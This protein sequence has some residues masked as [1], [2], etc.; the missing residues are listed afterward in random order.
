[1]TSGYRGHDLTRW[2]TAG[3]SFVECMDGCGRLGGHR[4]LPGSL[5]IARAHAAQTG[6]TARRQVT[7]YQTIYPRPKGDRS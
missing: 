3:G 1:M 4:T 2:Y 5:R 7:R 6:H